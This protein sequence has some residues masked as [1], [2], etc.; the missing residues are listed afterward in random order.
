MRE[1]NINSNAQ[2]AEITLLTII[3]ERVYNAVSEKS[4]IITKP[5]NKLI[6]N[7][8]KGVRATNISR[9]FPVNAIQ[10]RTG[11]EEVN[12]YCVKTKSQLLSSI[13]VPGKM[14]FIQHI[15]A[16]TVV[17]SIINLT[18][19]NANLMRNITTGTQIDENNNSKRK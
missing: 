10:Y 12:T 9:P 13:F 17:E 16:R 14:I 8:K 4:F 2:T 11:T 15:I 1:T 19:L 7:I 18:A 5:I 3:W 6:I